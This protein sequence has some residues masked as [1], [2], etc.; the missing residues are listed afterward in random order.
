MKICPTI[1]AGEALDRG[2][3]H[4]I[5]ATIA[6]PPAARLRFKPQTFDPS[7]GV[8]VCSPI[9]DDRGLVYVSQRFQ[10]PGCNAPSYMNKAC[11][12]FLESQEGS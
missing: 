11:W 2:L 7:Q 10:P 9:V 12:H 5:D 8:E 1:F 4:E 3:V 6:G